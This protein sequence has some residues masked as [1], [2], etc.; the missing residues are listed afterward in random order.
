M[1]K[2]SL[3]F[4]ECNALRRQGRRQPFYLGEAVVICY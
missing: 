3:Y 1:V 4:S 2:L